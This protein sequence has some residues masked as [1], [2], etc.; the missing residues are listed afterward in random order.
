MHALFRFRYGSLWGA[1]PI[2]SAACDSN[3]F[4]QAIYDAAL[5]TRDLTRAEELAQREGGSVGIVVCTGRWS[6]YAVAN[7]TKFR[8]SSRGFWNPLF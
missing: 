5:G 8:R 4:T 3:T 7:A 1:P 6:S 2:C